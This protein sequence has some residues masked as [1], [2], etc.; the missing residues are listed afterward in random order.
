M[1]LGEHSIT[2]KW[3]LAQK[4]QI[5]EAGSMKALKFEVIVENIPDTVTKDYRIQSGVLSARPLSC[6]AISP[7]RS[8]SLSQIQ[9]P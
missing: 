5:I 2:G 9:R 3:P 6:D 1:E 7:R 4:G 8:T